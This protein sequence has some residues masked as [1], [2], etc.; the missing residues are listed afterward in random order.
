M[1]DPVTPTGGQ[2]LF[3]SSREPQRE[4]DPPLIDE[5]GV[6]IPAGSPRGVVQIL[7]LV[8][9]LQAIEGQL[10]L[11][12]LAG[13]ADADAVKSLR[14]TIEVAIDGL[15]ELRAN[16]PLDFDSDSAFVGGRRA[17]LALQQA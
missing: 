16:F 10:S 11:T 15:E 17:L 5:Q 12:Q 1:P 7:S 3:Q 4:D 9:R 2:G 8:T 6:A 13:S 14:I